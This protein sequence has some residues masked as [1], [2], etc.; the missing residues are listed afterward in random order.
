MEYILRYL[1]GLFGLLILIA[2]IISCSSEEENIIP[3]NNSQI[4]DSE[5]DPVRYNLTV[6][7]SEGG[8]I[9]TEG[10]TYDEGTSVTVTATANPGYKFIGWE[11][12]DESNN[13]LIISVNSN[14]TIRALFEQI[15][16]FTQ[17]G[18]YDQP[19]KS[20]GKIA[21]IPIDF[22]DTPDEIRNDFPT[23]EKLYDLLTDENLIKFFDDVSY[24]IFSYEIEVLDYYHLQING[25]DNQKLFDDTIISNHNYEIQNFNPEDYDHLLFVPV[26]D[27]QLA[28]ARA[29]SWEVTINDKF[30]SMGTI[31]SFFV[32]I[33]IGYF[34]RDDS[35]WPFSDST[36]DKKFYSIPT[37]E[38]SS[39]EGEINYPLSRFQQTFIHEFIHSLGIGT[40][41]YSSTNDDKF[42]FEPIVQGNDGLEDLNYGD[43]F[44]IMGSGEYAW[45]LNA[46]YRDYLGWFNDTVRHR[47]LE[48]GIHNVNLHPIN[49]RDNTAFIEVRI[50]GKTSD[51]SSIG[52]KNEGY[53]IETRSK[54]DIWSS[55]LDNAELS[56]NI[57]GVFV[58]K[59]DGYTSWLLDMS[60][61]SNI[62][63]YGTTTPDLRDVVL[64]QNQNYENDDIK[65]TVISK[66]LNGSFDIEIVLK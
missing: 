15:T 9:S 50:P 59:T 46:A 22:L 17:Q 3:S 41:S 14:L 63:F 20:F 19:T 45:S 29:G 13:E 26:Y 53:F 40:H 12:I 34:D 48:K 23:K 43:K 6:T 11:G 37:G 27:K 62:N 32:P 10:G 36:K 51:F 33:M 7:S 4:V 49:T 39:V 16:S 35:M 65:I 38:S 8:S 5:P 61:S 21:V 30:Y 58:K 1:F 44:C 18:G 54:E 55:F 52:Y 31:Q 60:P 24:G 47:I 2:L 56:S 57:E 66:N 28:G 25:F 64:K 42:N